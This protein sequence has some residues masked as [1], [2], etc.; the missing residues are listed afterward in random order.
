MSPQTSSPCLAQRVPAP[1]LARALLS[2][3]DA[4]APMW[5]GDD[6]VALHDTCGAERLAVEQFIR[7]RFDE[8]FGARV[9][10][11]MPRLLSLRDAAGLIHG[12][13]G[14]RSA[15]EPLFLERYLSAPIEAEIGART[16]RPCAR[17]SVVEVGHL[18]GAYAGAVRL[19]IPRLTQV[20]HAEG[21]H[22]VTFTGT[23]S[24]RNAFQ[25]M[26][27][28]VVELAPARVE[29]LP[30]AERSAWGRYYDDAPRV[31]FGDVR[32]AQRR[33]GRAAGRGRAG[34]GQVA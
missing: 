15:L 11:F 21:V 29:C 27:L 20:M 32:E 4:A 22:W 23:L 14:L 8:A 10:G 18:S 17:R 26:G 12:A 16:G 28:A 19:M 9:A 2:R 33:L 5:A 34:Q 7:Q 13:V 25:R 30:P 6:D 1:V 31:F 3:P 24:L